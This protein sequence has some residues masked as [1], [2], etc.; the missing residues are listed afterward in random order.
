MKNKR[1]TKPVL[2]VF[3]TFTVAFF[4]GCTKAKPVATENLSENNTST[5]NIG[6]IGAM[7]VEV[8]TL[9]NAA[10]IKKT[11]T[12][13]DMEF[14]EGTLGKNSVV[15]VR[16]GMGKVNAGICANTLINHFNCTKI[17]N[18]GVAGSLNNDINIGDIVV[19]VDALQHDFDVSPLGFEKG[20]IPYTSLS[21]FPADENMRKAAIKAVEE[22]SPDIKAFEGRICSGDQ[23]IASKEQKE[24]I[25][26]NFGGL[27]CEMEGGAIAQT[28]YLNKTP[29]VIIRAISDKADDSQ[30]VEFKEFEA[31]AATHCAKIVQYMAENL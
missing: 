30:T 25:I 27:C 20:E 2:L 1:L 29:F 19:S 10:R 13:A 7:D 18:T 14:Y 3:L 12:I 28:C 15:I 26:S 23:F 4:T 5:E 16:C 8:D 21:A 11:T 22:T 6:I 24:T 9:K 17:I 31:S